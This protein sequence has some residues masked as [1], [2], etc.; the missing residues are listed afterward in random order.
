MPTSLIISAAIDAALS[1]LKLFNEWQ[2]EPAKDE[3]ELAARHK[4][5]MDYMTHVRDMSIA[6]VEGHPV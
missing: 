3:A 4:V 5:A 6:A 1:A 2:K